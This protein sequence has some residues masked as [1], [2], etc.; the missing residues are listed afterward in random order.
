VITP[1]HTPVTITVGELVRTLAFASQDAA[2]HAIYHLAYHCEFVL[3]LADQHV[4]DATPVYLPHQQPIA[5]SYP[6]P[7]IR[8]PI[9]AGPPTHSATH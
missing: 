6:P 4:T 2:R 9:R 3:P 5:I 1:T 7:T 8:F